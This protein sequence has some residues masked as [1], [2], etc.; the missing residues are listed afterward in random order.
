[1]SNNGNWF[2]VSRT[3]FDHYLVGIKDRPYTE[4]EAWLWLIAEAEFEARPIFNKGQR[5]VLDPGQMMTAHNYL[6][7]TWDWT[8][9]KVRWY[10]KRLQNEAMISRYCASQPTNRNTNQIQIIT[11]SNYKDYQIAGDDQHQANSQ[12]EHQPNPRPTPSQH[13][14]SKDNTLTPNNSKSPLPPLQGG[15]PEPEPKKR[16]KFTVAEVKLSDQA[17]TLWNQ[18][19]EKLG[20]TQ[21]RSVTP[22]RRRR[23]LTRITDI[24]GIAQFAVALAMIERVPF[25]LGKVPPKPGQAPFKLD[26]DRLMQSEGQLGDVLAKLVDK[27]SDETDLV[28]GPNNKPW[29]WWRKNEAQLRALP[30]DRWRKLLE[31][32]KPNGH[33]PWWDLTPWPGHPECCMHPDVI[34]EYNLHDAYP[35]GVHR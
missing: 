14:E 30:P 29:G 27:A 5:I 24:G 2:A 35:E 15:E 33:W 3:I 10:L 7:K 9:D 16:G 17:V 23:L 19:A 31:E 28:G 6:A 21:C 1:M 18:R 20:L 25:L 13:H 12:P 4:L 22:S 32:H 11:I 34:D 8:V 26:I